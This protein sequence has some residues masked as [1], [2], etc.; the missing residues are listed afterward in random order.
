MGIL[1]RGAQRS[2]RSRFAARKR[3]CWVVCIKN[4][5]K[6]NNMHIKVQWG[7]DKEFNNEDYPEGY[8]NFCSNCEGLIGYECD[9][10]CDSMA[11]PIKVNI[12]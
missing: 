11:K 6:G 8:Y 12:R 4:N 5:K 3:A 9:G 7:K 1:D 2:L 10:E